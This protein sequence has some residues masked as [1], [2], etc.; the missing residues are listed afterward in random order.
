MPT[1]I[2]PPKPPRKTNA[3]AIASR[4]TA[5]IIGKQSLCTVQAKLS[6]GNL[7]LQGFVKQ[8]STHTPIAVV[9]GTGAYDGAGG[10]A[11][12]TDVSRNKTLITVNL[13]H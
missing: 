4:A 1:T 8:H 7:S 6:H 3:K 13:V 10:T 5:T 2:S 12:V 11:F 9:G